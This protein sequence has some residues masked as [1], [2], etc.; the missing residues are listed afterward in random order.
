MVSSSNIT[1]NIQHVSSKSDVS[2]VVNGQNNT[3]FSFSGNTFTANNVPLRVG[4]NNIEIVGRN[5]VGRASASTVIVY[6]APKPPR[7]TITAPSQNPLTTSNQRV[8]ISAT[9]LEVSGR[10]DIRFRVNGQDNTNFTFSGTQFTASNVSLNPG[11][12]TIT[13]FAS[14][15]QGRD[16]KS[17]TII[18][19]Q[20]VP[21]PTVTITSP[22][23]NPFN[24]QNNTI[25]I[26]ATITNVANQSGVGFQVNGRTI[27][28]FQL[29]GTTFMASNVPLNPGNNSFVI[30]G[31]NSAGTATA[32]TN[33]IYTPAVARP[34]VTIT[35]PSSNPTNV[36]TSS[37]TVRA[38]IQNV[39]NRNNVS[40]TVNGRAVSNFMLAGTIFQANGVV[41]T[42]GNNTITVRATNAGGAASDSKVVVF[43][44]RTTGGTTGGNTNQTGSGSSGGGNTGSGSSNAGGSSGG[45]SSSSAK[46]NVNT[47]NTNTRTNS[48]NTK[49]GASTKSGSSTP[50]ESTT[51]K[52]GTTTKSATKKGGTR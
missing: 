46:K 27:T 15:A 1:A 33:V 34:T 8:N 44:P 52:G 50:T 24:T 38:T 47:S 51:K 9:I 17:T 25:R 16:S 35:I 10:G 41:L 23:T 11:S 3:N 4:N 40:M 12:N 48:S 31:T 22:S 28:N 19:Q 26:T 45:S 14:N 49:A 42:P 43:T 39:T 30:T 29:L 32:S 18:Y 5:S 21:R 7:V 37:T 36:S 13:I 6:Q 2:F 20:P